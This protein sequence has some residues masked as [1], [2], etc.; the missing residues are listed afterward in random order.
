M[1]VESR[2]GRTI[3]MTCI[4]SASLALWCDL[5][6][7]PVWHALCDAAKLLMAGYL[8][9]AGCS[10]ACDAE[11]VL[12]GCTSAVP[13][14]IIQSSTKGELQ[15]AQLEQAARQMSAF[16]Q[17]NRLKQL[18]SLIV[19]RT[20]PAEVWCPSNASSMAVYQRLVKGMGPYNDAFC[21]CLLVTGWHC[22][23]PMTAL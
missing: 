4:A 16:A 11:L 17:S 3:S 15:V 19:A 12:T 1:W 7:A 10:I 22:I 23:Q 18:A 2:R 6:Q 21:A 5:E 13:Q 14:D 9:C 20:S 8:C